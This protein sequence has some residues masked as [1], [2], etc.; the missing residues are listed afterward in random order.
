MRVGRESSSQILEDALR[1]HRKKIKW[2]KLSYKIWSINDFSSG[3]LKFTSFWND[4]TD[5]AM[6]NARI[7]LLINAIMIFAL[8]C[9][10]REWSSL[11]YS[12][13]IVFYYA[14]WN[15]F[16]FKSIRILFYNIHFCWCEI[17]Y[18]IGN[19]WMNTSF[20]LNVYTSIT[21]C[22]C[23]HEKNT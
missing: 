1:L 10:V 17:F 6:K 21:N 18:A 16:Q 4:T 7:V 11:Q 20:I 19:L 8:I 5:T 22:I 23:C 12:K 14:Y 15:S 9:I 3:Y 13:E 2:K